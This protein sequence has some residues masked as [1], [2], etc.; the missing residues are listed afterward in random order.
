MMRRSRAARSGGRRPSGSGALGAARRAAV[1]SALLL[2]LAPAALPGCD[3][4]VEP[5]DPDE[6]VAQPDLRH[7]FPPAAESS[8]RRGGP[9]AAMPAAPAAGVRAGAA[10]G[11]PIRG[12][13][14][15]APA[16]RDAAPAGAV[17]FVIARREGGGPPLAVKRID[18][19]SF[20]VDFE[21]TPADRMIQALPWGGPLV[22]TARLDRDG[23][24]TSREPGDLQGRASELVSPGAEGV[25]VVLDQR[26]E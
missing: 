17:L 18:A 13:V 26:I 9:P 19:P 8:A 25:Q 1:L 10:A 12:R 4:N 20:P 7:I 2:L 15:L 24:A 16:L 6:Q 21:L 22:L 14:E 3:R 23:N 11:A 5:F